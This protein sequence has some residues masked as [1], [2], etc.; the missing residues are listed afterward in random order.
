M[1][2][3][4]LRYDAT[5]LRVMAAA[6]IDD[7]E[8]AKGTL[9]R[10]TDPEVWSEVILDW[11]AAAASERAR[12]DSAP[13]RPHLTAELYAELE[14]P[15]PRASGRQGPFAMTHSTHPPW[16]ETPYGYAYWTRALEAE[17][18]ETLLAVGVEW[19]SGGRPAA[20]F[21]RVML[22]ASDLSAVDAR[23]KAIVLASDDEAEHRRILDALG[24]LR[25][26]SWDARPWLWIDVP[27]RADW[28]EHPP[29]AGLLEG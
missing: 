28:S 4:F 19:G 21:G 24:K 2:A 22:A 7:L 12:V 17:R 10:A 9:A 26:A 13:A 5:E 8:R 27:W 11:L 15:A 20:R 25:L 16:S 1:S 18:L 6:L 23:A 14:W 3:R 29:R